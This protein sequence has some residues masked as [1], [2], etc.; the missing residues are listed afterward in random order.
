MYHWISSKK[1]I[2]IIPQPNIFTD[3]RTQ[4]SFRVCDLSSCNLFI[5]TNNFGLGNVLLLCVVSKI[6]KSLS[7]GFEPRT[8]SQSF[9]LSK[10]SLFLV[11]RNKHTKFD[12]NRYIHSRPI[13]EHI[14]THPHNF[15]FI[16]ISFV[17]ETYD[18]RMKQSKLQLNNRNCIIFLHIHSFHCLYI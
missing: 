18:Y 9:D 8:F 2:I 16:Y 1:I 5:E 3:T 14:H 7:L 10:L 17:K 12:A 6:Q 11:S 4:D 15:N 13:S